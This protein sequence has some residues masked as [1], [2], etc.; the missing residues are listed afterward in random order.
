MYLNDC[1]HVATP[2]LDL[3]NII[4]NYR[5]NVYHL[6]NGVDTTIFRNYRKRSGKI[7]IG[8]AGNP[9]DPQKGV[10]EILIPSTEGHYDLHI[11]DGSFK[12]SVQKVI[13]QH[14]WHIGEFATRCFYCLLPSV[15]CLLSSV[16]CRVQND[17]LH[18]T[19]I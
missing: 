15:F 2:C 13:Y 10:R 16:L 4:S 17:F 8:W 6:P 9:N 5:N 14:F 3:M 19:L 1:K 11:A 18:P 7:K 12:R